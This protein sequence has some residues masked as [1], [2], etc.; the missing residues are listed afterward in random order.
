LSVALT[1]ALYAVLTRF[2]IKSRKA[3]ALSILFDAI[4]RAF[5][6]LSLRVFVFFEEH[7]A[8]RLLLCG[9]TFLVG[10][11]LQLHIINL[12]LTAIY[13]LGRWYASLFYESWLGQ[14]VR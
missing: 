14:I 8:H 10:Q 4:G 11:F 7:H 2:A 6:L 12:L 9:R 13:F 1:R 5:Q 3:K